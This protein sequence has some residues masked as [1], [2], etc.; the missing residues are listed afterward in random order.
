MVG[1]D[2]NV[3][4]AVAIEPVKLTSARPLPPALVA[5]PLVGK[6]KSS[7]STRAW[8]SVLNSAWKSR[9]N[10][11]STLYQEVAVGEAS[12]SRTAR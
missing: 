12:C 10:G 1:G 7:V 11:T 2:G 4:V 6:K 5:P 8:S 9:L 3:P